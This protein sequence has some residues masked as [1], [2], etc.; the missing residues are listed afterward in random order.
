MYAEAS[1]NSFQ[2]EQ[3]FINNINSKFLLVTHQ[4]HA[5][6][7]RKLKKKAI[8]VFNIPENSSNTSVYTVENVKNDLNKIQN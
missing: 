3:D 1:T 8:T 2:K 5:Y 6:T 4:I 7:E